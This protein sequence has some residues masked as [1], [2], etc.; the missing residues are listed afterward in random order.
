M[1]ILFVIALLLAW[2]TSGLSILAYIALMVVRGILQAKARMHHADKAQAKREVSAGA[3]RLPSWLADRDKIEEFVH[4]IENVAEHRGVP[5]LFSAMI[6]Q[7]P[8]LQKELMYYAG[9]M[10]AQGASFIGQ[11]MA[12]VDKLVELHNASGAV[13]DL[14]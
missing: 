6:L 12:A 14:A 11:Q 3:G 1:A 2:P 13:Q 10:E 5:K 9:S 7:D 8:E 4:G